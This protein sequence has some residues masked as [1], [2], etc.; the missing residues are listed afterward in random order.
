MAACDDIAELRRE[1]DAIDEGIL[2]LLAR[3]MEISSR[4]G[5]L[6]KEGGIAVVQPERWESVI[7]NAIARG[8][9]LGLS[10]DFVHSFFSEIHKESISRQ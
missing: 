8:R 6:K 2:D 4:I 1:I 3:R 5:R 7:G 10:E 9:E